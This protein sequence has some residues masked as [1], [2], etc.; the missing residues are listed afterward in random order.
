MTSF[1]GKH[2]ELVLVACILAVAVFFRFY[3][4][5]EIPI[6]LYPDEAMNGNN[7]L[8]ALETGEFKIFYPENNGRE[9]L[10][11]NIQALSLYLFGNEAWVLRVVS[12]FF[13]TL[14][15]LGLYLLTKELFRGQSVFV[16]T[17]INQ[18]Q[19][20][21]DTDRYSLRDICGCV[22][23]KIPTGEGIALLSSFFLAV[24]Y[25]HINFSRIGF[26]AVL[27]PFFM[28]FGFYWLLKSY[29]TG[30]VS[31]AVF[32]GVFIGLGFYTYI[33]FRLVPLILLFVSGWFLWKWRRERNA[34]RQSGTSVRGETPIGDTLPCAPCVTVLFLFVAFVT[35]MPVG[36]YFL[37]H[38]DDFSGRQSQVSVFAST[39]PIKEFII[40]NAKLAGMF[41]YRGDCNQRHNH[42]CEPELD[43][44]TGTF[45]LAG[46][47]TSFIA[48]ALGIKKFRSRYPRLR[49]NKNA[50][51]EASPPAEEPG[52]N[53]NPIFPYL[54]LFLWFAVMTLPATLTTEGMPHALRAIG[55]IPPV[56]IFSGIGAAFLFAAVVSFLE[57]FSN[58][59]RERTH[60]LAGSILFGF[61]LLLLSTLGTYD[62]YF[63][64]FSGH[65]LSYFA[66]SADLY[67]IGEYLNF[68][69][70][71]VKKYVIVNMDGVAVR[72][73]PMPAQTVMFVTGSFSE[74]KRQELNFHYL[75]PQDMSSIAVSPNARAVITFLN[76]RDKERV[77]DARSAFPGFAISLP[78]EFYVLKNY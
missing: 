70:G 75:L 19:K 29:R 56:F 4:I 50:H 7:A 69:P 30:R 59:D 11:I 32:A 42:N 22:L 68:L 9:G 54:F 27:V 20:M 33:A 28:T 37:N 15:V 35:A 6:G 5:T 72:G 62:R 23:S 38:P 24:S 31:S 21:S 39:N 58:T 64:R 1:F 16:P 25:W 77:I 52:S 61:L 8:E 3:Q 65:Q 46:L 53:D 18:Y 55:L 12:A 73:V 78:G 44:S 47:F 41:H 2:K 76:P 63:K 43:R 26:R 67:H 66:F 51:D 10:F 36:W 49:Q 45:F 34:D 74:R 60:I 57:R 48:L 17:R 40:S 13:G 71:D 14:T